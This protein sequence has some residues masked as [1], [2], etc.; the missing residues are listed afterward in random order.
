MMRGKGGEPVPTFFKFQSIM[1]LSMDTILQAHPEVP[2]I[3]VFREPV[4]V[5]QSHFRGA[6]N[7]LR[8]G[9]GTPNCAK[10]KVR[11]SK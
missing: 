2:W 5:M 10:A 6:G 1:T 11:L 4:Q 3:F 7:G 9:G 8:G